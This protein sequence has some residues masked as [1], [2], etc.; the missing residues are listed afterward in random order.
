MSETLVFYRIQLESAHDIK[1]ELY[2]ERILGTEYYIKHSWS[3]AYLEKYH[4]Q[5]CQMEKKLLI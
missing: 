1:S 5:F 4:S 2:G 3:I